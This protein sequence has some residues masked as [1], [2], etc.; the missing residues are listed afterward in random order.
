VK[1]RFII[2]KNSEGF[3]SETKNERPIHKHISNVDYM[4]VR[5]KVL[6][7][8]FFSYCLKKS[9]NA[10]R[11]LPRVLEGNLSFK[12]A[13]EISEEIKNIPMSPHRVVRKGKMLR[14]SNDVKN[15]YL[16]LY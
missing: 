12:K 13:L 2:E 3:S 15:F 6:K 7:K 10:N 16:N 14:S 1:I 5:I 8:N 11:I 9:T 4:V